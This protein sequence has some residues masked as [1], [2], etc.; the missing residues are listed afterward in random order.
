M[1]ESEEM[2]L[3][4]LALLAETGENAPVPVSRLA[5]ELNI[6]P[7]STNQMIRKLNEGGLVLYEPYK[8]IALTNEGER[9]ALNILR[10][11]RLW[12]VFLV[13]NLKIPIQEASDLACRMEHIVP[14]NIADRL[15]IFLGE[16]IVSPHGKPIPPLKPNEPLRSDVLLGQLKINQQSVIT[17]IEAEQAANAFL[18]AEGLQPGV[19]VSVLGIG[20]SNTILAQANDHTIFLAENVANKIWVKD[21]DLLLKSKELS[22]T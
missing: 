9:V 10:R 2:Y 3:V 21:P 12:E 4:T 16:P 5:S 15:A 1:S 13:E 18:C 14:E 20:H 22:P 11:R 7:V 8:G 17:Q 19:S 6:K